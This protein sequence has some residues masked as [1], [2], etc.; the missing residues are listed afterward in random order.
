MLNTLAANVVISLENARLYQAEQDRRQVA[1]GL[2]DILAVLN[3][4]RP[5]E[6]IL[7]HV[8]SQAVQLSSADAGVMYALV[9]ESSLVGVVSEHG[10][11]EAFPT[12]STFPLQDVPAH[13]AV[14]KREHFL[15]EDMGELRDPQGENLDP[16]STVVQRDFR[17][18]MTIPVVVK[19]EIFGAITL[20]FRESQRF[21]RENVQLASSF[22]DQ[23]ALAI[24]NAELR[25]QAE[26]T[27]VAEE[28]NRLA[29][30]LHDAVT[31]TL[32]SASLIAEVLP[33]IWEK[34]QEAGR[35]R[36]EELRE[37]TRGALAEM[38]SLLMEL[39]PK[40]VL[41]ADFDELVE[42]LRNGFVGRTRIHLE[43][44]L[45]VGGKPPDD[46]KVSLYR[47]I[48]ESLNNIAKH[49]RADL[50]KLEVEIQETRASLKIE[51][52]GKGFDPSQIPPDSLGLGIMRERAQEINAELKIDSAPGEGTRVSV[53]W[54]LAE[55][56][57]D[58]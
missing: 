2:R 26:K 31:Q 42:Q 28:R 58:V 41:E 36:L 5:L 32:F 14:L 10:M 53:N 13:K 35:Q 9:E 16:I 56:K 49:A 12:A 4:E 22:A 40:A 37:L 54:E 52:D 34:D 6:Q 23:A 51:D 1:E 27:A 46:V 30:D 24:E 21:S 55:E 43:Y 20:Y 29:R 15:V 25:S 3:S 39:R 47:I 17:S 11:P 57:N 18:S 19:E 8:I 44:N 33:R 7:S 50:V 38:R 45:N 48:Q